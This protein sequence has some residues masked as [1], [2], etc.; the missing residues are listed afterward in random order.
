MR[1]SRA[2]RE[3]CKVEVPASAGA[4][5]PDSTAAICLSWSARS[6]TGPGQL[7][8]KQWHA[9]GALNDLLDYFAP[10]RR[11]AGKPTDESRNVALAE[12]VQPQY[13][14]VRT[15]TPGLLELGAEGD[16]QQDPLPQRPIDGQIEQLTRGR[17]DP[18]GVLENHDNRSRAREGFELVQ[19]SLEQYLALALQAEVE[20]GSGA[21]QRQQF[22]QQPDFVI[23]SRAGAGSS[24]A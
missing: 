18:M 17:V 12:P 13:G 5:L 24:R 8:D 10:Q 16:N 3:A 6:S 22:G 7:L 21:W 9:I 20:A 1:S 23:A 11:V 15:A 19:Q 2:I 14:H 4:G